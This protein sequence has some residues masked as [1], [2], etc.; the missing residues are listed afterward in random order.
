MKNGKYEFYESKWLRILPLLIF[1][2]C[3]L[4]F[5]IM[6]ANFLLADIMVTVF[7]LIILYI[8]LQKNVPYIMVDSTS[9]QYKDKFFGLECR[10]VSIC[11][12]KIKKITLI[13]GPFSELVGIRNGHIKL[14]LKLD[15]SNSQTD[16]I[17]LGCISDNIRRSLLDV[18]KYHKK[19]NYQDIKYESNEVF[20]HGFFC[21]MFLLVF[22]LLNFAMLVRHYSPF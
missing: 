10:N 2:V 13:H 12:K 8:F 20:W 11:W 16:Y 7:P 15:L 4:P 19:I 6:G 9:I 14:A 3:I 18:I 17:R 5:V 1:E 22:F 21:C